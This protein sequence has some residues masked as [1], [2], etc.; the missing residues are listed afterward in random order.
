MKRIL[1]ILAFCVTLIGT[2]LAYMPLAF[3]LD[4]AGARQAGLSW[5]QAE[6][7]IFSARLSG[8]SVQSQSI[9][10]VEARLRPQALLTGKLGYTL[11]WTGRASQGN[12]LISLGFGGAALSNMQGVVQL[13]HIRGL[14][15]EVRNI[16]ARVNMQDVAINPLGGACKTASG[17]VTSDVLER[18]VVDY[19]LA[20][21]PLRGTID[22]DNETLN[23]IMNGS[24]DNQ[25]G[26]NVIL[27]YQADRLDVNMTIASRDDVLGAF[28][29]P[30]G[31]EA[32][33]GGYRYRQS[34]DLAGG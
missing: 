5:L 11:T 13:E 9:G 33:Q 19:G 24:L 12:A 29:T 20:S 27:Q 22:C 14:A 26:I 16:R 21:T 7:N 4:Q 23:L 32:T 30:L 15:S 25:Y 1:L 6:G 8:V 18:L 2:F 3:A 28:L 31:F 34:I 17:Q 10:T